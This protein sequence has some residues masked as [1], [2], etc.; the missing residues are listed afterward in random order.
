QIVTPYAPVG[1]AANVLTRLAQSDG[2]PPL[3]RIRRAYDSAA[4]PH[5]THG[6]FRFKD[7]IPDLLELTR[8][9]GTGD[10]LARAS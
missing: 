5:A 6:F 9:D 10:L 1:P 8:P 3:R 4:W 7:V 2:A